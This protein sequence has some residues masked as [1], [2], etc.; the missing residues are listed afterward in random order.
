MSFFKH[1]KSQ[2][3]QYQQFVI[4]IFQTCFLAGFK[5][6][7][8]FAPDFKICVIMKR[9]MLTLVLAIAAG[10]WNL[11]WAICMDA[12]TQV[13]GPVVSLSGEFFTTAMP[14]EEGDPCPP[15]ITLALS[16]ND[17]IHY[18]STT[19][20]VVEAQLDSII[21]VLES[22]N[23]I[24]E[25][26]ATVTGIIYT[27]NNTYYIAI[28]NIVELGVIQEKKW[29]QNTDT[30]PLFIKDGPGSSTV[31]PVD[32]NLIYATLSKDILSIYVL[33]KATSFTDS[34]STTITESG[35]YTI[36]LTNPTWNYTVVGTFEY[37]VPQAVENTPANTPSAT[38]I[39]KDGQLFLRYKGQMY[40]VQGQQVQ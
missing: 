30:I 8:N 33:R 22:V 19:D 15:C 32:P 39:L 7:S 34:I 13:D 40:N 1:P 3:T 25:Q 6:S 18:L 24:C 5:K 16:A 37:Q 38:K 21:K 23:C 28:S 2:I 12:T 11:N 35:I 36:E 14:C 27:R 20:S 4:F 10:V 17:N 29:H 31:E 9:I 26:P